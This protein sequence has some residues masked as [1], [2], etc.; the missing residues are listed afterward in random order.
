MHARPCFRNSTAYA[1]SPA[2]TAPAATPPKNPRRLTKPSRFTRTLRHGWD[3]ELITG[4]DY[5]LIRNSVEFTSA[6]RTSSSDSLRSPTFATYLP[7]VATSF[8]VGLR[9]R[10]R[11]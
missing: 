11:S 9:E 1:P 6:Q 3:R 8:A 10:T 4:S 2:N 7:H 5:F